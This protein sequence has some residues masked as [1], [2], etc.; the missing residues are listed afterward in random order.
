MNIIQP[1]N[2]SNKP[3]NS[4][5]D[6]KNSR[7]QSEYGNYSAIASGTDEKSINNTSYTAREP[8]RVA[9]P[10][11]DLSAGKILTGEIIDIKR[12]EV[13]IK[14]SDKS[15]ITLAY[16]GKSELK[17]GQEI[18]FQITTT[19]KTPPGM[20]LIDNIPPLKSTVQEALEAAGL[21]KTEQNTEIVRELLN[22][23]MSI[24]KQSIQDMVRNSLIY[25]DAKVSTLVLMLKHNIPLNEANVEQ[26]ENYRNY[27]HRIVKEIEEITDILPSFIDDVNRM[28][29]SDKVSSFN[30]EMINLLLLE[31]MPEVSTASSLLSLS[32]KE[33]EELLLLLDKYPLDENLRT[34]IVN[35]KV[36]L[37]D[38]VAALHTDFELAGQADE[39]LIETLMAD[40]E[41]DPSKLVFNQD[42]FKGPLVEQIME[43][44]SF[45]Q[46]EAGQIGAFLPLED[47]ISLLNNLQNLP[48]TDDIAQAVSTGTITTGEILTIIKEA[49]PSMDKNTAHDILSGKGCQKI[50]KEHLLGKWT[51]TP[52]KLTEENAVPNLYE[53]I[54]KQLHKLE[55]LTHIFKDSNEVLEKSGFLNKLETN[56]TNTKEN[57]NFMKTLNELFTYVQL[58]LHMK[59]KTVHSDLYVYTKK[60]DLRKNKNAVSALLRLD[61]DYLG[62]MDIHVNL[63]YNQLQ[64]K[65]YLETEDSIQLVREHI[66]ELE[67]TLLAKGFLVNSEIIKKEKEMHI[68]EDFIERETQNSG[69]KR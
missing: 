65:F 11:A 49:L 40:G 19:K 59:G 67:E 58:P 15:I 47:R 51:L 27:E 31:D 6:N 20:K 8:A 18:T 48:L 66:G 34:N 9:A 55:E 32:Q 63:H 17:I 29:S 50:I 64:T 39:A 4:L 12:N 7:R 35:G 60:K 3:S 42:A 53:K 21:P 52:G 56:V 44:F 22:H 68:V 38:L 25:K 10:A 23:Q 1:S 14:L 41:V 28:E 36:N 30:Q 16:K 57:L 69:L 62:S 5:A 13:S 33:S 45:Y 54:Y 37:T 46:H 26:F 43:Q 61:M 24:D 2:N